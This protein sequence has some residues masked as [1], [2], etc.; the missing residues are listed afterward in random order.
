[1]F[2]IRYQSIKNIN[3]INLISNT[4]IQLSINYKII[5][6]D[7]ITKKTRSNKYKKFNI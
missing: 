1:M 3:L 6:Y 7:E 4:I 2:E 5:T